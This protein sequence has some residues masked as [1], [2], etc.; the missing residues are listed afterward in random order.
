VKT[1]PATNARPSVDGRPLFLIGFMGAGKSTVGQLIAA[2]LGRA[3]VDVDERIELT[4]GATVAEIWA[5]EG[6]AGFRAR[7]RTEV[8]RVCDAGAP[9]VIAAGGGA[10][11]S[12]DNLDRMLDAGVVVCLRANA[13]EILRRVGDAKGRPLLSG[14]ANPR[15]EVERLLAQRAQ[16]YERAHVIVD[17][18]GLPP[19]KVV[20]AVL[21]A[22]GC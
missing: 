9:D 11:A 5:A 14:A 20:A 21:E 19:S 15:A 2:R 13:D 1:S 22:I 3:F 17:T 4:A 8:R 12:G 6:E 18:N 16:F 7:E 10:P